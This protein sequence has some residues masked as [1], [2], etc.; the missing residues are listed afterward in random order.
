MSLVTLN[1]DEDRCPCGSGRLVR[2]CCMTGRDLFLSRAT[3]RPPRPRTN[4]SATGC[5]ARALGDC[6]ADI[7]REHFLS[8]AVLHALSALG[9]IDVRG[10]SWLR[11]TTK[12]LSVNALAS[13]MLCSRH[14]GALSPLDSVAQ[15]FC[16]SLLAIRADSEAEAG[17]GSAVCVGLINGHDLER[18]CLKILIGGLYSGNLSLQGQDTKN[19]LPPS[20]WLSF[21]F[22]ER[23][24]A[25]VGGLYSLSPIEPTEP[26][27]KYVSVTPL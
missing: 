23:P 5:F 12:Q 9:G 25:R 3:T 6:S 20:E 19:R 17:V 8:A 2:G 1:P 10:P 16:E 24:F 15:R 7:T 21:L 26:T 11:G 13:N 4:H 14:N 22:G 18:W 27:S